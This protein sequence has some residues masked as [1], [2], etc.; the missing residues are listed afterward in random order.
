MCCW[1]SSTCVV[2][3]LVHV[4]STCVVRYLVHG[5]FLVYFKPHTKLYHP[6]LLLYKSCYPSNR[7][8]KVKS[9]IERTLSR[10]T[11][12]RDQCQ[13]LC[14]P[15]AIYSDCSEVSFEYQTISII[16]ASTSALHTWSDSFSNCSTCTSCMCAY[17]HHHSVHL[18]QNMHIHKLLAQAHP[19][20]GTS[21]YVIM[22]KS[23][24]GEVVI[25]EYTL[26]IM[27]Q[28]SLMSSVSF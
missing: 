2:R 5:L 28:Y 17:A 3:Y 14:V 18:Y 4:S 20:L 24:E 15:L 27:A 16:P 8:N 12:C 23:R 26:E 21:G 19:L 1:V 7:G 22:D 9:L 25:L 11:R 13:M 6:R 10:R